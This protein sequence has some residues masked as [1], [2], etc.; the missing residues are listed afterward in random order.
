MKALKQAIV[1]LTIILITMSISAVSSAREDVEGMEGISL[2]DL[3]NLEITT[4]GKKAEKV[5]EIPAS[6]VIVTRENIETYGY[7]DLQEILENVPGIYVTDQRAPDDVSV[8]VRGFWSKQTSHVMILV[9]GVNQMNEKYKHFSLNMI[10][11]PVEAI[12]RIEVVRGP[13]SVIYGS[14]AFYGVINIITNSASEEKSASMISASY[15]TDNT[16]KILARAHGGDEVKF[17]LNACIRDKDGEDLAYKD[18]MTDPGAHENKSVGEDIFSR[19]SKYF[20]LSGSYKNFYADLTHVEADVGFAYVVPPFPGNKQSQKINNTNVLIGYRKE[21]TDWLDVDARFAFFNSIT[22][23]DFTFLSADE[24][25]VSTDR[26]KS[27]EAEIDF[28]INP[29]EGFD[30]TAGLYY[31]SN[32]E[33]N[34]QNDLPAVGFDNSYHLLKDGDEVDTYAFFTQANYQPFEK[35]RLT[36]GIR[37]EQEKGYECAQIFH[38][39]SPE[40]VERIE[41]VEDGDTNIIP[42]FAALYSL[43]DRNI[44][45]FMYGKAIKTPSVFDNGDIILSNIANDSNLSFLDAEEI[46]TYELNYFSVWSSKL[47][48]N[49]SL[50]RN[51][52]DNLITRDFK[53]E[54]EVATAYSSNGGELVTNGAELTMRSELSENFHIDLAVTYQETEDQNFKDRDVAFSPNLLGYFKAAYHLPSDRDRN[55]LVVS[56]TG[57]YVDSMYAHWNNSPA[58]D[59]STQDPSH[60]DY[61]AVGRIGEKTD[62]YFL[63]GANLRVNDL[64]IKGLDANL[65]ISNL[66]DEEIHYPTYDTSG[67]ADKGVIGPGREFL[68]TLAY[69]F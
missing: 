42:R 44:F 46:Q 51:T 35:L 13:M 54:D 48:I 12:Q 50:F 55:N 41:K 18:M 58:A 66:F 27:Y 67:W 5:G 59:S 53:I 34:Q 49:F 36:A 52:L 9:N 7:K 68:L 31:R 22:D 40:M 28:F 23:H 43:D 8:N 16:K 17:S 56:V 14:G 65:R 39:G 1:F 45:K 38:Q 25:A 29:A 63:V 19:D 15:G 33:N 64:F 32:Y 69:E 21:V 37:F 30:M 10:D 3:L 4:A 26:M 62:D 6:V 24:Y 60:P 57:T 2:G 11:V 47:T 20:N 61:V